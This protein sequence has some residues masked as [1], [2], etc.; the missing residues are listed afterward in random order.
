MVVFYEL[1]KSWFQKRSCKIKC[2]LDRPTGD[3]VVQ[4]GYH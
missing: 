3:I 2:L 1:C 4:G